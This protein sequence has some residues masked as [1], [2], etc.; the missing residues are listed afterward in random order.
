MKEE[1]A[2]SDKAHMLYILIT[3]LEF[4]LYIPV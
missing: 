1:E 3:K 2:N 4:E